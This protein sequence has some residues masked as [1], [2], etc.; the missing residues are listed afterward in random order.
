MSLEQAL[1]WIL[2][3][4][5]KIF[6]VRFVKRTDNSIREMTCRLGVSVKKGI[7]DGE[8]AYD[9]AEHS[10]IWVYDFNCAR[11]GEAARRSIPVEGLLAIKIDGEW[12]EVTK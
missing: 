9:P 4:A 5:S 12:V 8:R 2:N 3:Q 1:T 10:L 7:K 11:K 6:T